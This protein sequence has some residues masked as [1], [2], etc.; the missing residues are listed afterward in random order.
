MATLICFGLGYTC[1]HYLAR[2]GTRFDR[3]VGTARTPEKAAALT[4]AR[5]A[6]QAH[7]LPFDGA[8]AALELSARIAQADAALVSVP[9]GQDGDPVLR[10][11][12]AALGH[13]PRLRSIVYLSTIGVYGDTGGQWVDEASE[14]R[15]GSPRSK[16]RLAAES[17]WQKF[18]A[19]T[20]C[21][22]AT[23]RL[24]GI[25]GPGRNALA[26]LADGSAK[27]I[28]KPGQ[29]FNRI[30][31]ADIAQAI[32]ACFARKAQGVFNV[33]DDEPA[34]PQDVIA[35]AASLLEVTPPP[36]IPFDA[37]QAAM[38]PMAQSFYAENRRVRNGKL[39]KE[40]G[41]RLDYPTYRDGL[42][43]LFAAGDGRTQT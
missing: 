30:H 7:V 19:D 1:E 11:F 23:L 37:V 10:H 9:P 4:A 26:N 42:R 15:A 2:F 14:A 24:G 27:R 21:A 13:S 16:A 8:T 3:V 5:G 41:V 18:A 31:V 35:F 20:G 39:K 28:V 25:Y 29:V 34:P 38:T 17:A 33:A 22:L 12:G 6:G 32:D 43:A 40:L 36:E